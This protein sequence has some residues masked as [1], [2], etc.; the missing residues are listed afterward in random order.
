MLVKTTVVEDKERRGRS[1]GRCGRDDCHRLGRGGTGWVGPWAP[2]SGPGRRV[3]VSQAECAGDWAGAVASSSL[4]TRRASGA[5]IVCPPRPPP[6]P[7]S[8]SLQ[9]LTLAQLQSGSPAYRSAPV[10]SVAGLQ[11]PGMDW[12]AVT[13]FLVSRWQDDT[14]VLSRSRRLSRAAQTMTVTRRVCFLARAG[15][16]CG[17]RGWPGRTLRASRQTAKPSPFS[18][19]AACRRHA[20][21]DVFESSVFC[22]GIQPSA[23]VLLRSY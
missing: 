4:P 16:G 10:L 5:P 2:M 19:P 12:T 21:V 11:P 13:I 3:L 14:Q 9:L 23:V 22:E 8:P 7:L 6:P 15:Q 18:P 20:T 1:R 17:V